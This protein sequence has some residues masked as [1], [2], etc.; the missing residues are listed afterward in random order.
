MIICY[1][2]N[3]SI[4]DLGIQNLLPFPS[5]Y[6]NNKPGKFR[7]SF[8]C[9]KSNCGWSW[10]NFG[11]LFWP[12][13]TPLS[14]MIIQFLSYRKPLGPI[15]HSL[16]CPQQT[17][18]LISHQTFRCLPDRCSP[19]F[20]KFAPVISRK[21]LNTNSSTCFAQERATFSALLHIFNLILERWDSLGCPI[22]ELRK[23]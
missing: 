19:F 16:T 15:C 23:K 7:I 11:S 1:Y 14:L 10:H 4:S 22:S 8:L 20:R 5:E 3:F 12:R 21:F 13:E 17:M 18:Q 2:M 6:L 9:F